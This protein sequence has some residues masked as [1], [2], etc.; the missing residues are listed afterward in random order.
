MEDRYW[1]VLV[2]GSAAGSREG[3]SEV[4]RQ[5]KGEY[6]RLRK[7]WSVQRKDRRPCAD[8]SN[9]YMGVAPGRLDGRRRLIRGMG[10]PIRERTTLLSGRIVSGSVSPGEIDL[11]GPGALTEMA[12][13]E[14]LKAGVGTGLE[15]SVQ[16][17]SNK[18]EVL[19]TLEP[20]Q[21]PW[22]PQR[23]EQG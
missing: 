12:A 11:E 14:G 9:V 22:Q 6:S 5:I 20:Q 19:S 15:K 10:Q 17:S 8:G 18:T 21:A 23:G 4:S 16:C 2:R 3:S 7:A 13:R 1:Q